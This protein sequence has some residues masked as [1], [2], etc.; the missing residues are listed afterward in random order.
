[1]REVSGLRGLART[2]LRSWCHLGE[3]V[4][5]GWGRSSDP[6]TPAQ[7]AVTQSSHR[8]GA[9]PALSSMVLSLPC[10]SQMT[11]PPAQTEWKPLRS[12]T[13]RIPQGKKELG[14]TAVH[15]Q[16]LNFPQHRHNTT[17]THTGTH[18]HTE[19]HSLPP[20]HR[21]TDAHTGI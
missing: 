2:V 7:C 11:P 6:E 16:A 19:A 21:H 10:L 4:A 13:S 1:M 12:G 18:T 14:D 5:P 8:P 9:K 3:T 20:Q 15:T 17:R